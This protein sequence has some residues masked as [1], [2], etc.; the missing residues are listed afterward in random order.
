MRIFSLGWKYAYATASHV[1][2]IWRWLLGY[3]S[4]PSEEVNPPGFN[5]LNGIVKIFWSGKT[6]SWEL[7]PHDP[8]VVYTY[9]SEVNFDP[10][11]DPED[12]DRMLSCLEPPEQKL[13]LQTIAIP[14]T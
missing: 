3:F 9:I 7:V 10:H 2:N 6:V 13:F 11:A 8:K 5:C 12:C 1:D 4:F 14:R